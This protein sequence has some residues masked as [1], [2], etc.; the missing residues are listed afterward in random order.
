MHAAREFRRQC[1]IYHAVPVDAALPP[2]GLRHNI[3][4][5]VRFTFGP[6][7]GMAFVL[8]GF[9]LNLQAFG[10]ESFGQLSCDLIFGSHHLG[11]KRQL[12]NC[13]DLKRAAVS[14]HNHRL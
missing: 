9:V 14:P 10:R 11:R 13:Q 3:N 4:A 8:V 6:M 5:E 7:A 2:E 1:G 12:A